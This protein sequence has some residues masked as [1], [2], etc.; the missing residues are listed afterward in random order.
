MKRFFPLY[1]FAVLT[2]AAC[3]SS[4]IDCYDTKSHIQ[5]DNPN[6]GFPEYCTVVSQLDS[7]GY[8]EQIISDELYSYLP[9]RY[10]LVSYYSNEDKSFLVV[11]YDWRNP[12]LAH[13]ADECDLKYYTYPD[14]NGSVLY[15]VCESS[16]NACR[17]VLDDQG[18]VSIIICQITQEQ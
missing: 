18:G 4:C 12:Y 2:I 1:C 8:E 16:G 6:S 3:V 9:E 7:L 5:T 14:C 17:V 10:D 13:A 11:G 15:I